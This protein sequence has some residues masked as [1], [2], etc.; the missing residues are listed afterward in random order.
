MSSLEERVKKEVEK[1][2][3]PTEIKVAR[4]LRKYDWLVRNQFAY[5]DTAENKLRSVDIKASKLEPIKDTLLSKEITL[6]IE[7]KKSIKQ[8][9]AFYTEEFT[10]LDFIHF[11]IRHHASNSSVFQL[12]PTEHKI[13]KSRIAYS[14]Q[15]LFDRKDD[16]YE[17]QMQVLKSLKYS[18]VYD[19]KTETETILKQR[20]LYPIIVFDGQIFNCNLVDEDIKISE[21]QFVRYLSNGLSEDYTPVLIDVMTLTYLP[22]YL[23]ALQIELE[24]NTN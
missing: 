7:C 6:Y 4:I 16:F 21:I 9:W 18:E 17:A 14:Y 5:L 22:I 3:M 15:I 1:S 12:V 23:E 10:S 8:S 19:T 11:L 20:I 2:G 24:E 13:I